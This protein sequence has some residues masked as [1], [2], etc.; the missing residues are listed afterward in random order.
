MHQ[1]LWIRHHHSR[2]FLYFALKLHAVQQASQTKERMK[3]TTFMTK[4]LVILFRQESTS[5]TKIQATNREL[6]LITSR[7]FQII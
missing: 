4:R 5:E 3:C 6:D 2:Y 7:E 1:L